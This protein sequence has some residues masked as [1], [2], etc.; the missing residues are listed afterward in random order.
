[1]RSANLRAGRRE[2]KSYR[3]ALL[4]LH[5]AEQP[6]SKRQRL[7]LQAA[8]TR[9]GEVAEAP[10]RA[11]AFL[12]RCKLAALQRCVRK[13]GVQEAAAREGAVA[14]GAPGEAAVVELA[15]VEAEPG[16]FRV[17]HVLAVEAQ[18]AR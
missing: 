14:E 15:V 10:R 7:R 1:L 2:V 8:K 3:H 6:F 4:E 12:G 13:A 9:L 16:E 11:G 5:F 17:S 18:S